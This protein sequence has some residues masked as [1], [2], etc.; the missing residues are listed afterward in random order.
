MDLENEQT[1]PE[2]EAD[3]ALTPSATDGASSSDAAD[4]AP[5]SMA[6]VIAREFQEKYGDGEPGE[7]DEPEDDAAPESDAAPAEAKSE[8]TPEEDQKDDGD[9]EF[10]IPDEQFK[11]LP[12]GVKKRLGHLNARAKK[13]ER[14]IADREKEMEPLRD[15][16]QR[17]T[18]LQTFVQDNEIEPQNVTLAFNAMAAMSRG[19]YKGFLDLVSPWVA[20]AQQATGA[21]ISPDLQQRVDDGYLSAEDA[22][23][24]TRS[25][26]QSQVSQSK[27]EKLT[28]SQQQARQAEQGQA[29][30][31]SVIAAIQ[32][33]EAEIKS[34]DPDYAQ[35]A[36]AMQAMVGFALESGARPQNA[37]QAVQMVNDAYARVNATFVRPT[38]PK[39]TMPRP[40][41]SPSP[42]GAPAPENTKDAIFAAL[43]DMPSA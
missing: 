29:N 30:V 18:Q 31:Q 43:R 40:T 10:R 39:A 33:R 32:S 34:S 13:A 3:M 35:K 1:A 8:Q 25:R 4:E 24:I 37:D 19:D 42:R 28:A 26:V 9:D 22:Q 15:A 2:V 12:D 27:L 5:E 17:F 23:E 20:V 36:Q 41:A 14:E 7:P 11:A 16:H 6:D 38:P 21:A